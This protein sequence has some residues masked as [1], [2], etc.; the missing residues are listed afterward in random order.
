M[1]TA[2]YVL[3]KAIFSDYDYDYNKEFIEKKYLI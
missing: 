2:V 3:G 1:V